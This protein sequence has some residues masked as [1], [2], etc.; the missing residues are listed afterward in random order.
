VRPPNRHTGGTG[1]S[2]VA[3]HFGLRPWSSPWLASF[4]SSPSSSGADSSWVPAAVAITVPVTRRCLRSTPRSWLQ[5]ALSPRSAPIA[6]SRMWPFSHSHVV[7]SLAL[8]RL[9]A[10]ARPCRRRKGVNF[11]PPLTGSSVQ[12]ASR[13]PSP[14][15]VRAHVRPDRQHRRRYRPTSTSRSRRVWPLSCGRRCWTPRSSSPKS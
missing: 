14:I 10:S 9:A 7:R 1:G 13:R 5:K 4:S 11:R 15:P 6:P 8:C 2:D 12:R 3:G